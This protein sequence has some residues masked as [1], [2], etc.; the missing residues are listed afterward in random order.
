[1]KLKW[2]WNN[3]YNFMALTLEI[4]GKLPQIYVCEDWV[5]GTEPEQTYPQFMY[6]MSLAKYGWE[7]IGEI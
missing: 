4:P 7:M 1:M 3:K 2:W 5:E 6:D